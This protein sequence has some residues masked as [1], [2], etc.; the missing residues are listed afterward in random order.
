M[1]NGDNMLTPAIL[2][3]SMA[4]LA[5]NPATK[6]DH[7]QFR[8]PVQSAVDDHNKPEVSTASTSTPGVVTVKNTCS[9][10]A[11]IDKTINLGSP[12]RRR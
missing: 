11:K 12:C 9:G 5:A 8:L 2:A 1:I 7:E 4:I 6:I 3:K 10:A